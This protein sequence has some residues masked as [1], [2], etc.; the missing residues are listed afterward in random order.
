[1]HHLLKQRRLLLVAAGRVD[2]DDLVAL[3]AELLH[4]LGGDLDGV[5]LGVAAVKGHAHARGV[6][7]ELVERAR[8]E[9][10]GAHH[11]DLPPP[12]LVVVRVL[13]DG[14]RLARALQ[15][16]E[17]D[18]V[19]LA[20]LGLEGLLARLQDAHQ[21]VKHGALDDARLVEAA[22]VALEADARHDVLAHL[23]HQLDVDVCLQQRRRDVLER[24]GHEL[25]VHVGAAAQPLQ[26]A[27]ELL[28]ERVEHHGGGGGRPTGALARRGGGAGGARARG[29]GGARGARA[30]WDRC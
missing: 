13:G 3:P 20:L 23:R 21:L 9:R 16:D 8:A 27:A 14:G 1:L 6:L 19:G 7:L 5:R 30:G 22:R 10:V 25:L 29:A 2:D 12:R 18:D 11:R 24:L 28:G 15:A 26:R 4:A 17:H